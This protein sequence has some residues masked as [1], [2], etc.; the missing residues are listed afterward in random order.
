MPTT[1][2]RIFRSHENGDLL[3]RFVMEW[4]TFDQDLVVRF[5]D[6]LIEVGGTFLAAAQLTPE[7]RVD[8]QGFNL[9][10]VDYPG[11]AGAYSPLS[12]P[13]VQIGNSVGQGANALFQVQ[14]AA[15]GRVDAVDVIDS[16][17]GYAASTTLTLS[18]ARTTVYPSQRVKLFAGF[19]YTRRINTLSPDDPSLA[20]LASEYETRIIEQVEEALAALRRLPVDGRDLTGES[21][22]QP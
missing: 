22:V 6:P 19:P 16:G 11:A 2:L 9:V 17:S 4:T 12:P 7:F 5:G 21:V 13:Q 1:N 8:D 20:F 15:D 10:L 18:N 3:L 14:L